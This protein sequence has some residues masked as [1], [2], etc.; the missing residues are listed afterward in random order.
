MSE[1]KIQVSMVMWFH[2]TYP[3]LR[4]ML[5]CNNNN[6][7]DRMTGA[8]NKAMGVYEGVS[9]LELILQDR[10]IFIEVKTDVGKLSQAQKVFMAKVTTLGHTFIVIRTLEHF[11]KYVWT[12]IGK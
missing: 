5:H 7:S 8:Q 12:V 9:D 6:S 4:G 1:A 11:K 10:V 3:E 2:N